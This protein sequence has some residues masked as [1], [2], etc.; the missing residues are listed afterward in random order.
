MGDALAV[1]RDV[2]GA[3]QV[4]GQNPVAAR[5]RDEGYCGARWEA[6]RSYPC[7]LPKGHAGPHMHPMDYVPPRDHDHDLAV[8]A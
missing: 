3:R 5:G 2:S 7:A 1:V 6:G 4:K 8:S